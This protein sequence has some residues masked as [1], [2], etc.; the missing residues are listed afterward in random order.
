MDGHRYHRTGRPW[1]KSGDS[2]HCSAPLK[3]VAVD[4]LR[5]SLGFIRG[6]IVRQ[7]CILSYQDACMR[8]IEIIP[9][10]TKLIQ[11]A[12]RL[13]AMAFFDNPLYLAVFHGIE[14]EEKNMGHRTMSAMMLEKNIAFAFFNKGEY[15]DAL[16]YFKSVLKRLGITSLQNKILIMT[17]FVFDLLQIILN[18]YVIPNKPKTMT[19]NRDNDIFDLNYK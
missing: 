8:Y 1:S 19:D 14:S 6:I 3:L 4:P 2:C 10:E 12:A 17:K 5:K 16:T 7:G 15:E 18:L 11:Q 13:L 9:L